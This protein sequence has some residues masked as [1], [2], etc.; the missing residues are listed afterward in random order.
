MKKIL[1]V[2]DEK[3]FLLMLGKRLASE[4]YTVITADNGCDAVALA[5]AKLPDIILLDVLIPGI[6]GGEIAEK[7]K[8]D[9]RTK[10]IPVIFLTALLSK[11]EEY[12]GS[13]IIAGNITFAKPV[14]TGELLTQIKKLL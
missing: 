12:Q 4:G 8:D 7:L 6:D 10:N 3:D 2:D 5:K 13:H 1:I 11:T 14:D 9:F